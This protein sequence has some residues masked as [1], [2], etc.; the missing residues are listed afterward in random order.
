M[1]ATTVNRIF[2]IFPQNDKD[3]VNL[4]RKLNTSKSELVRDAIN[5]LCEK[6]GLKAA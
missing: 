5:L 4:S 1:A 3:L 2:C 6:H